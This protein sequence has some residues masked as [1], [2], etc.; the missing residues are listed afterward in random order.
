M[1]LLSVILPAYNEEENLDRIPKEL[2]SELNK[3][4]VS[5]EVVIVD[6]GSKDNTLKKAKELS[7][8]YP[9][10]RVV[11]H[12][13]NKGLGAAVRTGIRNS[14][15]HLI[16]TLDTDFT[17]HPRLIRVLLN[18]F[19][20]GDVDF[21]SGSS[22]L[23][24]YSKNIPGYRIFLSNACNLGYSILFAKKVTSVSP[25]FRLYKAEQVKRLKLNSTGFD[26]NAEIL[27]KL[28]ISGK[29]F[30]EVPAKLTIRKYG[31]SKLNNFR[32]IKNHLKMYCKIIW[33]RIKQLFGG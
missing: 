6:D 32:E 14:K 7:N 29:K 20:K 25:I 4:R 22:N 8:K 27:A 16:V 24:G 3:L 12:A 10:I 9:H 15:G 21:V 26:I 1:P 13:K 11:P 33:W 2:L 17:F 28:I 30:A 23:A 5:Y 31:V 19:N 18:R